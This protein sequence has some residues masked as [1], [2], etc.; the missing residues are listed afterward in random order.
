MNSV[1]ALAG[2]CVTWSSDLLDLIFHFLISSMSTP[3]PQPLRVMRRDI[4]LS[5][6]DCPLAALLGLRAS[7]HRPLLPTPNGRI[8]QVEWE[9]GGGE[10]AEEE[11]GRELQVEEGEVEVLPVGR[12]ELGEG[13]GGEGREGPADQGG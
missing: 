8:Q 1:P 7:G 10:D 13:R 4:R 6:R 12:T 11:E 9:R 2:P 5:R 3:R